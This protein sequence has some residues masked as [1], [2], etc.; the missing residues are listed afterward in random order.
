MHES[1][2]ENSQHEFIVV[3]ALQ[4]HYLGA[5]WQRQRHI[6][7]VLLQRRLVHRDAIRLRPI[8]ALLQS[9]S[10]LAILRLP[11]ADDA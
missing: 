10:G 6:Q 7:I 1:I 2:S 9:I 8:H 3:G 5:E 11:L 4:Q